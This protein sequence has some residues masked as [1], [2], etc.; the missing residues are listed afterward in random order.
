MLKKLLGVTGEAWTTLVA[1]RVPTQARFLQEPRLQA[2][3]SLKL[4]FVPI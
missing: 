3:I 2:A 1:S 4:H